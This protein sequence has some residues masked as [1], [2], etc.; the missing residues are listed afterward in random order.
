M[1]TEM[2]DTV[3]IAKLAEG[4]SYYRSKV[5]FQLSLNIEIIIEDILEQR[6]THQRHYI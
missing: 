6:L 3:L 1:A 5:S 4:E 2:C